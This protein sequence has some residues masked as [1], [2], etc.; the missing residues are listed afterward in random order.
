MHACVCNLLTYHDD[1]VPGGER[2][3]VGAGDDGAAT[4][5]L[6]AVVDVV[7]GLERGGAQREVGRHLLLPRASGRPVQEHGGVVEVEAEE[8]GGEA[9]V[10]ARGILSFTMDSALGQVFLYKSK[11]RPGA[12]G[13]CL[14]LLLLPA[15]ASAVAVEDDGR[16]RGSGS[17][18]SSTRHVSS[19]YVR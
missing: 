16:H 7:D 9:D 17:E 19:T 6:E 8:A 5:P 2:E 1:G 14:A 18:R 12:S 3:D 4:L 10:P 11:D 13:G 15:S